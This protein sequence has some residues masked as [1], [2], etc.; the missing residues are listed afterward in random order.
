MTTQNINRIAVFIDVENLVGEMSKTATPLRLRP[1]ID[2]VREEGQIGSM[3]AYGDWSQP[4]LAR[5]LGEF[6]NN[7]IEMTEL[8]TSIQGKNTADVQLAVDAL[9]MALQSISPDTVVIISGD[10]D[11]IPLVQ[12]LKRYAKAVIG[13][14]A[15]EASTSKLLVGACDMF[16][17]ADDLLTTALGNQPIQVEEH[18]LVKSV[19]ISVAGAEADHPVVKDAAVPEKVNRKLRKAFVLLANAIGA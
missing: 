4:F 8:S 10:R 6:R 15:T 18:Q 12:K 9:E 16:L 17:F 3:R 13:I 2:R 14:G 7:I 1:I 11:F 19:E 5:Y